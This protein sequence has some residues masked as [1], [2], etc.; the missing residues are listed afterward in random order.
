MDSS[1]AWS[2]SGEYEQFGKGI[3]KDQSSHSQYT[4]KV[5]GYLV[6][7]VAPLTDSNDD[8]A[9]VHTTTWKINASQ[10]QDITDSAWCSLSPDE[11]EVMV[12]MAMLPFLENIN[13]PYKDTRGMYSYMISYG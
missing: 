2:W 7:P 12:K 4:F 11:D 3:A 10:L 5:P 6:Y 1:E 9:T 8:E 13:L